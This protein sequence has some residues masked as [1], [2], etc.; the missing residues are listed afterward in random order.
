VGILLK[1]YPSITVSLFVVPM[2]CE[3]PIGQPV[4]VCITQNPYLTS[5]EL[6]DWADQGSRL[7]VDVFI[8]TDY[9]W[10]LVMRLFPRVPVAQQQSIPS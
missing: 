1:G 2:I 7:E 9:Y 6:A 5:L 4:D 8:G 10:D 3:P